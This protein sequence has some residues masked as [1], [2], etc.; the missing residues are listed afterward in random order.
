MA[1]RRKKNKGPAPP[2]VAK[3]WPTAGMPLFLSALAVIYLASVW[4]GAAGSDVPYHVLPHS[5]LYFTQTACLFPHS[6]LDA[7]DY[8]AE[9][10]VC[11]REAWAPID[12]HP[13][14]PVD[15]YNK[16]SR[17]Q[18]VMHFY[19]RNER[20]MHALDAYLVHRHDARV[21]DTGRGDL[22]GG[23]RLLDLRIPLGTP[24]VYVPRFVEKPL[25][26]YPKSER[27]DFYWTPGHVR[28]ERCA[29]LAPKGGAS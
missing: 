13:D 26:D 10:W 20:T 19:R 17:F 16:E 25:S 1:G 29:K 14:F 7:I 9:G 12:V 21:R 3:A 2:P 8:R 11:S 22:I 5:G 24:G 15:R 28:D 6:A 23:V 18:R 4:L 27:H